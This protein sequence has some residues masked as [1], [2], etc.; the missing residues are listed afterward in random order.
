VI[1]A[2]R[3]TRTVPFVA[4]HWRPPPDRSPLRWTYRQV[5]PK[6][7][8]VD[9]TDAELR[10]LAELERALPP[11]G[12]DTRRSR[13]RLH[14]RERLRAATLACAPLVRWA[15]WLLPLGIAVMVLSITASVF[16]SFFGAVLTACGMAAVLD[17][18]VRALRGRASGRWRR[19]PPPS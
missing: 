17:R 4:T 5:G 13:H 10:V 19:C 2:H 15:P 8:R 14:L 1:R 6:R 3:S 16:V 18:S 12:T 11:S 9:L 7:D